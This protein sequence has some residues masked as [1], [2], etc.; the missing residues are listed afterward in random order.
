MFNCDSKKKFP[1]LSL[2]LFSHTTRK[3]GILLMFSSRFADNLS[4]RGYNL[5]LSAPTAN[6]VPKVL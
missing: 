4:D 6:V 5:R 1:T 3:E 2:F